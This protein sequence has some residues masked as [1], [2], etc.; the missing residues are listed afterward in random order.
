VIVNGFGGRWLAGIDSPFFLFFGSP[1]GLDGWFKFRSADLFLVLFL[2]MC[3]AK[4]VVFWGT[5]CGNSCPHPR[6]LPGGRGDPC[7]GG[8]ASL[9]GLLLQRPIICV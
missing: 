6:P 7:S 4:F 3:V 2:L 9:P 8:N 1:G 5:E